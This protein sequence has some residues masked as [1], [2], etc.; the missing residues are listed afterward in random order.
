MK[1]VLC[2]CGPISF[3]STKGSAAPVYVLVSYGRL[4]GQYTRQLSLA[5]GHPLSL[6]IAL[7][8]FMQITWRMP[9]VWAH[10]LNKASVMFGC[11]V[12]ASVS[13]IL[14]PDPV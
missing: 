9:S 10:S 14:P 13:T 4:A 8:I 2:Q 1:W 7:P 3:E 5:S 6:D 11:L 12:V